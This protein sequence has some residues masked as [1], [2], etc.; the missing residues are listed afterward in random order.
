VTHLPDTNAC[1]HHL[2]MGPA[3]NVTGKLA[4]A[5]PGSIVLCSV[6]LANLLY[7]AYRSAQ[8]AQTL[9]QVHAFTAGFQSLPFDDRAAP[10]YGSL[11]AHLAG[12]GVSIGP[13]DLMIAA[14]ALANSLTLVTHNTAEFSRVRGLTIE[15]W[16]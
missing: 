14:I 2:R 15:D 1:I 10:Q 4:A 12:L 3:S 9:S 5:A 16:Q 6:V 7:G 13:N 8:K 11:R